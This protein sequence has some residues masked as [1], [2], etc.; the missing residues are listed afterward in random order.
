MERQQ[1]AR[2][3][4]IAALGV[5]VVAIAIVLFTGGSNYTVTAQFSD[6]G[7]LVSGDIVTVAGHQVGSVGAIKLSDNGLADIE[8]NFTDASVEPI[9][10][11]TIAT[12]GQLSLTGVANRFVGL[13]LS[14]A[15]PAIPNGGTLPPTQTRGIVDLDTVLDSLT[16]QVRTQ[17]QQILQSGAYFIRQPT[18]SQIG[19]LISYL[20]PAFSQATQ[21]GAEIVSD[22]FALQRLV[23]TT[24]Q[25][26]GALA[27]RDGDLGGAVSNTAAAL[28]EIASERSALSDAI[29]RAPAVLHQA[30]PVLNDVDYTLT[31]L[32][33]AL[34]NLRPV[35]PRLANLLRAVVPAAR[36]AIPTIAGVQ[37]LVPGAKRALTEL[38]PIVAEAVPAV[39]SLTVALAEITPIL[40]GL[41]P[42]TPDA[43][44]GFFN[45]VGG[46]EGGSYDANGHYLKALLAVQAGGSTLTG[47]L[48]VLGKL[49]GKVTPSM[50]A[51]GGARTGLT[52]P[53][54]GG[55][56]PPAWDSSAPWTKPDIPA[57]TGNL[58]NPAD[59]QNP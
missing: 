25:L 45:G 32:D 31:Q 41:R 19:Q 23:A 4:A 16:P 30:T 52:A 5:A 29:G 50:T 11:G 2:W 42:Y 7:Q 44:A 20:N 9:H 55:G 58:C 43:V 46:A 6:A 18:A 47:V 56:S 38:P 13:T 53:C 10:Q 27:A 8:L 28:R 59:D 39:K 21:L 26:T 36:E 17:L 34:T 1:L 12:I 22:K 51:L 14:D 35:A 33:P 49:L 57:A 24:A 37:A 48:N 40:A 54:P 3:A 15:G